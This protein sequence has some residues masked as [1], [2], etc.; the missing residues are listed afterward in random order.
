MLE[1]YVQKEIRKELAF[2]S[3][4][5][6]SVPICVSFPA[7]LPVVCKAGQVPV[8]PTVCDPCDYC[9]I[10]IT[11]GSCSEE[12]NAKCPCIT[13][14]CNTVKRTETFPWWQLFILVVLIIIGGVLF[15]FFSLRGVN[16]GS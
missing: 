9:C 7:Y 14:F 5:T 11:S 6:D 2:L 13:Q 3:V 1:K 12:C 8:I 15:Q 4:I 16:V 10:C